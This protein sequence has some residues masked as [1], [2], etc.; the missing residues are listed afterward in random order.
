[1]SL[2]ISS[3]VASSSEGRLVPETYGKGVTISSLTIKRNNYREGTQLYRCK[4]C[5]L[6]LMF[7]LFLK[8]PDFLLLL[9]HRLSSLSSVDN[10]LLKIVGTAVSLR[11]FLKVYPI[12]LDSKLEVSKQSS[13]K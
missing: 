13:V 2:S 1:M 6:T 4:L 8:A 7:S 9:L 10:S 3:V 5:T 12:S 11:N